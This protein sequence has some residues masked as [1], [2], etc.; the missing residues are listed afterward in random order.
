MEKNIIKYNK[1]FLIIL[2]ELQKYDK[3]LHIKIIFCWTIISFICALISQHNA[4]LV[5]KPSSITKF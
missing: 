4:R 1:Y 2:L 5:H 3:A